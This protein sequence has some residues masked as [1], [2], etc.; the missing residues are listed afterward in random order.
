MT[1]R[2]QNPEATQAIQELYDVVG[3][4]QPTVDDVISPVAIIDDGTRR[5]TY[6]F[7]NFTVIASQIAAA[8]PM[9]TPSPDFQFKVIF[10]N[11]RASGNMVGAF[12]LRLVTQGADPDIRYNAFSLD[13]LTDPEVITS[14][15]CLTQATPTAP[16]NM[17][18]NLVHPATG[19]GETAEI[20]CVIAQ[21]PRGMRS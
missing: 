16:P 3:E 19:V 20:R 9:V 17:G 18:W 4:I 11:I 5:V 2:I 12:F 14:V 6:I 7:F 10:M 15:E 1:L 13:G 8:L 21:I